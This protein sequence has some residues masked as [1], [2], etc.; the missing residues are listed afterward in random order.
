MVPRQ[1]ILTSRQACIKK[2]LKSQIL[3]ASGM[4]IFKQ[5]ESE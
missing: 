5:L 4:T 2:M 1:R 3:D